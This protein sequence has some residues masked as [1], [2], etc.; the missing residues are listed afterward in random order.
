M[1]VITR[2]RFRRQHRFGVPSDIQMTVYREGDC[3]L[4]EQLGEKQEVEAE[5]TR[6]GFK[7]EDFTLHVLRQVPQAQRRP[8]SNGYSATV[9]NVASGHSRVYQRCP[10]RNWV[11][12]SSLDPA[13]GVYG[14]TAAE[15]SGHGQ[16]R[17]AN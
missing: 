9:S 4:V 12:Q 17:N 1:I 16:S 14:P 15:R 5:L 10:K 8:E 13:N 7:H 3:S 6:L 2:S 11:T